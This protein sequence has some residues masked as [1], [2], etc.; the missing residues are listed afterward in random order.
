MRIEEIDMRNFFSHRDTKLEFEDKPSIIKVE[1]NNGSG[2]SIIMSAVIFSLLKTLNKQAN[3]KDIVSWGEKSSTLKVKY[4]DGKNEAV[5]KRKIKKS[6]SSEFKYTQEGELKKSKGSTEKDKNEEIENYFGVN[7]TFMHNQQ[8][9]SEMID[10]FIWKTPTQRM[11]FIERALNLDEQNKYYDKINKKYFALSNEIQIERVKLNSLKE[12]KQRTSDTVVKQYQQQIDDYKNSYEELKEQNITYIPQQKKSLDD[13]KNSKDKIKKE[14]D[15][16]NG[17]LYGDKYERLEDLRNEIVPNQSDIRYFE[18]KIS[19]HKNLLEQEICPTCKR[20]FTEE[21]EHDF[22]KMFEQYQKNIDKLKN[23]NEKLLKEQKEI[24]D[25]ID[26][27]NKVVNSK[28]EEVMNISSRINTIEQN[29]KQSIEKENFYKNNIEN[30]YKKLESSKKELGKDFEN[31]IK[32]LKDNISF[33]E[34]KQQILNVWKTVFGPKSPIR[35]SIIENYTKLLSERTNY[36][37]SRLFDADVTFDFEFD[38]DKGNLDYNIVFEGNT[39]SL[40]NLSLGQIRMIE[41]SVLFS[42]YEIM[43]VKNK[44]NLKVMLLDEAVYGLSQHYIKKYMDLLEE[45]KDTYGLQVFFISHEDID[46]SYFDKVI[47]VELEG[48]ESKI[49]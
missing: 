38:P 20:E 31:K 8:F 13:L 9:S 17:I 46:E 47:Q 39:T 48:T 36:Y 4:S 11:K 14:I 1:G 3:I 45:F 30:L 18:E 49:I 23:E 27:Q 29:V 16:I 35:T 22:S 15:N 5:I 2:K 44:N 34:E 7:D 26:E 19:E 43:V 42:F 41:L 10:R 33:L 21:D 37:V 24:Q 40:A 6:V 32:T 28:Q 25:Y 12:E